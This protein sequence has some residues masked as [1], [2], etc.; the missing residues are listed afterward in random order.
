ML[1]YPYVVKSTS[2]TLHLLVHFA[3]QFGK[4]CFSKG[5][6]LVRVV[7]PMPCAIIYLINA[8]MILNE[9]FHLRYIVY[10][11]VRQKL[12]RF[13]SVFHCIFNFKFV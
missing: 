1:L 12:E 13:F 2:F 3:W 7:E 10:W 9:N 11:Y 8:S 6:I 4:I 5:F